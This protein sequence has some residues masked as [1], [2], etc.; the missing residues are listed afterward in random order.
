M[1]ILDF[2]TSLLELPTSAYW[3]KLIVLLGLFFYIRKIQNNKPLKMLQDMKYVLFAL[4]IFDLLYYFIPYPEFQFSIY[5]G[6]YGQGFRHPFLITLANGVVILFY[7]KSLSRITKRKEWGIGY[8][9]TLAIIFALGT[10]DLVLAHLGIFRLNEF[11]G[12]SWNW[13]NWPYYAFYSMLTIGLYVY[14]ALRYYD[15]SKHNTHR[16]QIIIKTRREIF[17]IPFIFHLLSM[18]VGYH[19]LWVQAI[20]FP[21]AYLAHFYTL[22]MNERRFDAAQNRRVKALEFN[23]ESVFE[24]MTTI[25]KSISENLEMDTVSGLCSRVCDKIH[26]C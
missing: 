24:F 20:L 7:L 8:L 17:L 10:T 5:A 16:P 23:I 12:D 2:W 22:S 21:L 26:Q 6:D 14:M 19:Q 25:Q 9:T 3:P 11:L 1:Q 4:L 13:F 18:V 15:V